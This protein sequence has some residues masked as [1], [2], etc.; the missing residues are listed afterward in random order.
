AVSP[1]KVAHGNIPH[2]RRVRTVFRSY[3]SYSSHPSYPSF[4]LCHPAAALYNL[5][6]LLRQLPFLQKPERSS[7]NNCR[8]VPEPPRTVNI[9]AITPTHKP[10]REWPL[11]ILAVALVGAVCVPLWQ[12]SAPQDGVFWGNW[13]AERV[14]RLLLGPEQIACYCAFTWAGFIL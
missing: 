10:T 2:R 9:M 13:S 11:L 12:W 14:S 5:F 1:R 8:G 7:T 6:A 3:S 4:Q